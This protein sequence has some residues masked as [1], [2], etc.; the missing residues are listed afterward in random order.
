MAVS[1]L[2]NALLTG[3]AFAVDRG[4]QW[5]IGMVDEKALKS[6]QFSVL[7]LIGACAFV[8]GVVVISYIDLKQL[9]QIAN[10]G[11][12]SDDG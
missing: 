10:K 5:F 2:A 1:I 9:V 8:L 3:F 11:E 7:H 12:G 4:V 6:T